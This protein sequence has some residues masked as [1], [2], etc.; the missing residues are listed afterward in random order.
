MKK[1][2]ELKELNILDPEFKKQIEKILGHVNSSI[3]MLYEAATH[4]RKTKVYNYSFFKS[5]FKMEFEKARRNLQ[6]LSLL[7]IDIDYFKKI[8]DTYGHVKADEMLARLGK[9]LKESVRESDIVSRFGGEEFVVLFPE[10]NLKKASEVALRL[11]DKIKKDSFLKKYR[12]TVSGGLTKYE[13]RDSM[14][15]MQERADKALYEAK[16]KGRD[17]I[18][19]LE[20]GKKAR[21]IS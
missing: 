19:V 21:Q 16:E 13:K 2:D 6:K 9:I 3:S 10:T 8:N 7:I 1:R 20:R 11:R 12:L 5:I 17:R 4:D 18:I 15:T 14:K